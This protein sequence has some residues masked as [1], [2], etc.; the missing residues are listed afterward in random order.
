MVSSPRTPTDADRL[1]TAFMNLFTDGSMAL[2][3]SVS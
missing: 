1:R 3:R 2:S